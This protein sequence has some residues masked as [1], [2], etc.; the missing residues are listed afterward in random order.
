MRLDEAEKILNENGYELLDEGKL[1]R[2]LG[3]GALALGSLVGNANA[4]WT[5]D[6]E[7]NVKQTEQEYVKTY[8]DHLGN[9]HYLKQISKSKYEIYEYDSEGNLRSKSESSDGYSEI[10]DDKEW[11]GVWNGKTTVYDKYGEVETIWYYKNGN[12]TKVVNYK[13]GEPTQIGIY[14]NGK[15]NNLKCRDGRTFTGK[16]ADE[17]FWNYQMD[18]GYIEYLKRTEPFKSHEKCE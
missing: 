15:I 2:A 4:D 14:K 16:K 13:D 18:D 5:D 9:I 6:F 3:I 7:N 8:E 17:T 12:E 10:K 1:G 11:F